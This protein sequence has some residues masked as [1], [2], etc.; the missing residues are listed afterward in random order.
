MAPTP[1]RFP[2]YIGVLQKRELQWE[3]AGKL[4]G[5]SSRLCGQL[6]QEA[7]SSM[8][9]DLQLLFEVSY[10]STSTFLEWHTTV[11]FS[12]SKTLP[13]TTMTSITRVKHLALSSQQWLSCVVSRCQGDGLP[14]S[15]ADL[16]MRPLYKLTH[17]MC[18]TQFVPKNGNDT[19]LSSSDHHKCT[20]PFGE[21][22]IARYRAILFLPAVL[23]CWSYLH[24]YPGAQSWGVVTRRDSLLS[25]RRLHHVG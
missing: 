15:T 5:V 1:R 3:T 14:C 24:G 2:A 7:A 12:R 23:V 25:G 9:A 20:A 6:H 8:P 16:T 19:F 21:I 10:S 18:H 4:Y 22:D 13:P 11:N 17:T